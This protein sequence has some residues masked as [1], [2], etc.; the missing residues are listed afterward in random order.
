MAAWVLVVA[1]GSTLVWTVISRAG[2]GVVAGEDAA[3]APPAPR[4]APAEP[5]R[6]ARSPAGAHPPGADPPAVDP[7]AGPPPRD[8][9]GGRRRGRRGVGLGAIRLVGAYPNSGWSMRVADRGPALV[10]I[11]FTGG[12][13]RAETSLGARCGHGIPAYTV[14]GGGSGDGSG[15]G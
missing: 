7:V 1:V 12:E 5:S 11:S 3:G 14:T 8:L 4:P 2:A 10:L 15:D 6:P 13:D 9:A